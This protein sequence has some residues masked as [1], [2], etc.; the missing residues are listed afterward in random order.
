MKKLVIR[1]K[2][3]DSEK[4]W[5]EDYP[6]EVLFNCNNELIKS[7]DYGRAIVEY[8]NATMRPGDKPRE[9]VSSRFEDE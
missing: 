3:I 7:D 5:D 1:V 4:E 9:F 6:I 2:R 8:Y